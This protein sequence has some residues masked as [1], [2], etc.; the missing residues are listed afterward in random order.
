MQIPEAALIE[1]ELVIRDMQLTKEVRMTKKS[2]VRWLALALG[3]ISP[4]E[5]RKSVIDLL[6]A[7]FYFQFSESK[8]PDAHE[9]TEY[10]RKNREGAAVSEKTVLYHLLQLKNAGLVKREKGRYFFSVSPYSEKGDVA[11]AIEYNYKSRSD[12]AFLKIH[13]ALNS[14]RKMHR[15]K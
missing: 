9:L 12:A 5:S 15:Q 2:L 4:N 6:E 13:E 3:L 14:L 10:I 1:R 8:D 7:L 11:G